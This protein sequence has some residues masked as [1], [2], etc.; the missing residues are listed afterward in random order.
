[1]K[2]NALFESWIKLRVVEFGTDLE[3]NRIFDENQ[4]KFFI[5]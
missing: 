5:S 2:I 3:A 1:M 4:Y